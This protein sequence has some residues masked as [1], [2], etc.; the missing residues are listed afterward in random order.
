MA[1]EKKVR[2]HKVLDKPVRAA[3]LLMI[4]GFLVP[5]IATQ[6][7]SNEDAGYV[8]MAIIG[9]LLYGV[10]KW[11]FR[12]EYKGSFSKN[13]GNKEV[14]RLFII[15]A[16]VD[17]IVIIIGFMITGIAS[18]AVAMLIKAIVAGVVEEL[19][20]RALPLSTMMRK[21]L[22]EKHIMF[23]VIFT[24]VFFGLIHGANILAGADKMSTVMQIV[25][26]FTMGMFAAAV[27]LRTGNIW[28]TVVFHAVH[29]WFSFLTPGVETGI[30][31]VGASVHDLIL[32]GIISIVQLA[33][34][35]YLLRKS[36]RADIVEVWKERWSV[37]DAAAEAATDAN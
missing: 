32:S 25:F 15:V 24:S 1:K 34:A 36:V 22:D 33:V 6:V 7:A 9:I 37:S 4:W 8:G 35:L 5:S 13:F 11:W 23:A 10:H 14:N 20:F 26:A 16:V 2:T 18:P 31:T 30:V 28:Y 21:W 12:P 17:L 19:A 3:I 27:Y 29:D